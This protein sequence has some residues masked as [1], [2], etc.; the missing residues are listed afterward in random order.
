MN[1]GIEFDVDLIRRYDQSGPRYT[2]YPTAVSFTDEFTEADYR[3]AVKNSNG[4]PV[5]RPLSLYF[6]IPFCDTVCFYCACNKIA[7]KNHR[8]ATEY[9][10]R[11]HREIE[12]QGALFDDDRMVEQL[13][14]GGG[15]PTF[16]NHDEMAE[17]M[18]VTRRHFPLLDDDSGEYSIEIDPR[19]VTEE[20]VRHLRELGFNR[21]SLGVQDVDPEVQRA[22]NRIQPMEKNRE[23][24]DACRKVGAHSI[25]IDLI[26]GLPFQTVERFERTLDAVIELSP[27]RLSVFN[28]AHLPTHFKPQRRINEADLPRQAEKLDILQTTIEKLTG[29]GY[30]YVGMDHFAKPDD[31][32]VKA[33]ESGHLHRNFQG[34][35]THD[36]CE[37]IG[38]GVSSIGKVC[39]TYSQNEK[40]LEGYYAKVDAGELPIARGICLTLDDKLRREVIQALICNFHLD[41]EVVEHEYNIDFRRY[42][43]PELEDLKTL[44]RDD[45]LRIDENSITVLPR[46]RLLVR[47][48][49][50]AFDAR[51]RQLDEKPRFSRVI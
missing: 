50:M 4:D 1:S 11:L 29:A 42:F 6:H 40:T 13:H 14:W 5:P 51:L 46:G 38:L 19:S 37:L 2:S 8:L 36:D 45:L 43:G 20:T 41:F 24:I 18:A 32:L 34:Y 26:Y 27:D 30:V 23:I 15:T 47:N 12:M 28:Y 7:T 3:K 21:F 9:L 25:N 33:Q 31:Q 10:R 49:C 22:V 16:L 39:E 44:A 35:T 17:L 48:I